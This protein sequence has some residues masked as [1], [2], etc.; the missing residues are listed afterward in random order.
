[1][2][3]RHPSATIPATVPLGK[4]VITINALGGKIGEETV[5]PKSMQ[6][7]V[8][9]VSPIDTNASSSKQSIISSKY[10][11]I[12]IRAI[13]RVYFPIHCGHEKTLLMENSRMDRLR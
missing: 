9:D 7:V 1:M 11:I 2:L 5:Q 3:I 10:R 4:Y 6:Y 13:A 12:L 8:V